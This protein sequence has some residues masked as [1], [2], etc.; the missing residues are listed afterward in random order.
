MSMGYLTYLYNWNIT[1]FKLTYESILL[2]QVM[3]EQIFG[4]EINQ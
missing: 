3:T 1:T 2:S 4:F